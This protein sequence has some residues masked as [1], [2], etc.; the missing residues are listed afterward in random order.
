MTTA[1]LTT[2]MICGQPYAVVDG[3]LC[4]LEWKSM[5]SYDEHRQYKVDTKQCMYCERPHLE[6]DIYC[7]LHANRD[8]K[9]V[10][11]RSTPT[12]KQ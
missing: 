5:T 12:P 2:W 9:P 8:L 1:N 11:L 3:F 6:D 4:Q 7:H 10:Q